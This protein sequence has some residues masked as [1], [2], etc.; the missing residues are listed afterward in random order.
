MSRSQPDYKF[1]AN[2]ISDISKK[3]NHTPLNV[4]KN[5]VGLESPVLEV[6]FL[7]GL[8]SNEGVDMVGTCGIG[9]I[10]KTTIA[11]AMYNLIV[12]Q[13]DGLCFLC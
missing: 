6:K 2:I 1:I 8:R 11:R 5:P 10:G 4:A 12:D 9:G 7:I 13:F 3:L